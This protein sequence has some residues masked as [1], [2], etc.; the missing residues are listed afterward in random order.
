MI[1]LVNL[2]RNTDITA[3]AG[4]F[5]RSDSL[6]ALGQQFSFTLLSNPYDSRTP[7]PCEIGDKIRFIHN[8]EEVFSGIIITCD[9]NTYSRRSYVCFDYAFYLNKSEIYIQFNNVSV[10]DAIK[11]IAEQNNIPIGFICNI[12]TMITKIYKQNTISDV[13]A[14]LL[15]L[16]TN[17]TGTKYKL[18]VRQDRLYIEEYTSL[19]LSL[20]HIPANGLESFDPAKVIGSFSAKES[21][22]NMKNKII[23]VSSSEKNQQV[24]ADESDSSNIS[25]FGRLQKIETVD[26]KNESQA[27]NIAKKKLA[28]LNKIDRTYSVTL[29][30]D[31]AVRAGRTL[32]FDSPEADIKGR[33]IVQAV[34]HEY[35]TDLQ[36]F[37]SID[38]TRED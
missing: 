23:V 18:E 15:D 28:E 25:T 29:F 11:Q 20:S 26:D 21:V 35:S 36:H 34:T 3:Y 6:A 7:S 19:I 5:S 37:M 16:A 8:G 13:I 30:G 38:M 22:E 14:D 2:S 9:R 4:S 1:Q 31:N 32:I 17:D 10:S 27:R 12:S 33:F 24:L